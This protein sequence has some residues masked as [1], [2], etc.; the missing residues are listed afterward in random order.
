MATKRKIF[1]SFDYEKDVLRV[2]QIRNIGVLEGNEPVTVNAWEEVR[3]GGAKAV[4]NWI[5]ENMKDRSCV[6]VL[7]GERTTDRPWVRYEIKK[8][9][10]EGKGLLGIHIHN[11]KCPNAGTSSAGRNPFSTFTV[12][13]RDMSDFVKCYNPD[14]QKP[15]KD[16]IANLELWIEDAIRIRQNLLNK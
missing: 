9:W 13:G 8:A 16:I 10:A 12:G 14:S 15:N 4:E 5:N 1:Y 6:I 7:V 2:Q 11:L 3:K